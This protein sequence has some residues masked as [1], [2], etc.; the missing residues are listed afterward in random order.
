MHF[1]L[2]LSTTLGPMSQQHQQQ[3]QQQQMQQQMMSSQ[4]MM[5]TGVTQG[6]GQQQFTPTVSQ[7]ISRPL[8][9]GTA[10]NA[11]SIP[12]TT[13]S[14]AG[15]QRAL[16]MQDQ[17]STPQ[18]SIYN[19]QQ[20]QVPPSSVATT[21]YQQQFVRGPRPLGPQDVG[22]NVMQPE[23]SSSQSFMMG[24][25]MPPQQQQRFPV[26]QP[27][28]LQQQ[29]PVISQAQQIPGPRPQGPL[30]TQQQQQPTQLH[31]QRYPQSQQNIPSHPSQQQ[32]PLHRQQQ[33]PPHSQGMNI[34]PTSH[35]S[36]LMPPGSKRMPNIPQEYW[37][38]NEGILSPI[39]DVSPSVEAAEQKSM[40]MMKKHP[41]SS[42]IGHQ[43]HAPREVG[44][45]LFSLSLS[46]KMEK[47]RDSFMRW[48]VY[49]LFLSTYLPF[50]IPPFYFH[51]ADS[52]E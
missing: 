20:P 33:L 48:Y 10:M 31:H 13:V 41:T 2:S 38:E 43:H 35:Q 32:H 25:G 23:V 27:S 36:N 16:P 12:L 34:Y 17:Y 51:T 19:Q 6:M 1:S 24:Q 28:H 46:T 29:Q 11:P 8:S 40:E 21:V 37:G 3:I 18:T 30:S 9:Q 14:Q 15:V 4:R 49:L 7:G 45:S 26:S 50:I 39:Q 52:F 47:R 44:N 22:V 42:T 5:M